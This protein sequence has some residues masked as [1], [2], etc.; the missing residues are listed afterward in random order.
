MKLCDKCGAHNSD[1][2][3]FCVDCGETLGEKLSDA[4]ERQLQESLNENIEKMYNKTDPLHV[5]VLDKTVGVTALIG[6][7]ASLIGALFNP[8]SAPNGEGFWWALVFFAITA[9]DA[10]VPQLTWEL[11]KMRL[12][13]YVNGAD[14]LRP[15]DFYRIGRRVGIVVALLIGIALL[16]LTHTAS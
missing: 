6:G 10:F 15:G 3:V 8:F 7:A 2:R 4:H 1:T 9:L 14:D 5:S 11:E 12:G 13:W 16:V